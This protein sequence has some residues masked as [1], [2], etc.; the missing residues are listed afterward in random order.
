MLLLQGIEIAD[1]IAALDPS[2]RCL[3]DLPPDSV[4]PQRVKFSS[5]GSQ[6]AALTS[7]H[8]LFVWNLRELRKEL[9]AMRLDWE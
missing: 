8:D 9:A 7:L 2:L 5:D 3:W 6:L 1:R 4:T